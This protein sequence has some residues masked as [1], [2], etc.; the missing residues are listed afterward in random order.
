VELAV[1]QARFVG[2]ETSQFY[3]SKPIVEDV[4]AKSKE[5]R[6]LSRFPKRKHYWM[7]SNDAIW[8]TSGIAD[9]KSWATVM[10]IARLF[11]ELHR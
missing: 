11:S 8:S 1:K 3:A 10:L 4:V 5:I 6:R 9:L 2:K 7:N